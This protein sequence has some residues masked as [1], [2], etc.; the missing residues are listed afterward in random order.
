[1]ARARVTEAELLGAVCDAPDDDAPRLVYAD[2]LAERGD[3]RGEYIQL[4]CRAARISRF[5]REGQALA[6]RMLALEQQ[7][8]KELG[9]PLD[10]LTTGWWT[11]L[12]RGFISHVS[13]DPRGF[14]ARFAGLARRAPITSVAMR[15]VDDESLAELAASPLL[16]RL[17]RLRIL[18]SATGRGLGALGSSPH[19][20]AGMELILQ[21]PVTADAAWAL[22]TG[23]SADR[24]GAL[25]VAEK[26]D[27]DALA[28]LATLPSLRSLV[29]LDQ[30]VGVPS[31]RALASDGRALAEI[32]IAAPRLGDEGGVI[33]AGIETLARLYVL[34]AG[35]SPGGAAE[36]ARRLPP[37]VQVLDLSENAIGDD[38]ARA[39]AAAAQLG[40]LTELHLRQCGVGADGFAAILA[41]PHL[42]A[43]EVLWV[44]GAP[45]EPLAAL[46]DPARLP[47][48][49]MVIF[50]ST[51]DLD[52]VLA[53]QP[54]TFARCQWKGSLLRVRS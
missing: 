43:L 27:D 1:V 12:T 16:A 25:A 49:Q 7:L 17:S 38:G 22:A 48:L 51:R 13:L 19:L 41:S 30:D 33:L 9:A 21:V 4:A 24:I 29:V 36:L 46:D 3:P 2:W 45:D 52:R 42:G 20:R 14:L 23:R 28:T 34:R 50:E 54:R 47:A 15:A 11:E 31:A 53:R 5:S 39:I 8:G 18:G 35:L 44:E 32:M 10:D 6:G 26:I 40:R 37:S